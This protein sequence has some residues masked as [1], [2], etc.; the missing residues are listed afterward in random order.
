MESL[1]QEKFSEKKSK[2]KKKVLSLFFVFLF[3]STSCGSAKTTENINVNKQ[4]Q[5][6]KQDEKI[7]KGLLFGLVTYCLYSII[8]P[9]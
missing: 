8:G 9:K 7:L 4:E 6:Y 3:L 5:T 2:M 1:K